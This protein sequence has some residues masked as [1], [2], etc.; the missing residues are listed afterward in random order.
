MARGLESRNYEN[1]SFAD[2]RSHLHVVHTDE[3]PMYGSDMRLFEREYTQE[4]LDKHGNIWISA[5]IGRSIS[6]LT[7]LYP[8]GAYDS[9]AKVLDETERI[10]LY[11][12]N[13]ITKNVNRYLGLEE[14]PA[15]PVGTLV[16]FLEGVG[17]SRPATFVLRKRPFI[18]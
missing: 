9:E 5:V 17:F 3:Q 11:V 6:N 16:Q 2:Q 1:D 8:E 4:I 13:S 7:P 15:L 10:G 18:R 12:R 14:S